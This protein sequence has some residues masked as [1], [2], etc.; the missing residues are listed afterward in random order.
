MD[1]TWYIP[2]RKPLSWLA[3]SRLSKR[4]L[5][6]DSAMAWMQL[7]SDVSPKTPLGGSAAS[8]MPSRAAALTPPD[9]HSSN[10]TRDWHDDDEGAE[11]TGSCAT[12]AT[13]R[14]GLLLLL[15]PPGSVSTL[16]LCASM[17]LRLS[18]SRTT[19][20]PSLHP[21][22]SAL[23]D[24]Q[25]ATTTGIDVPDSVT[26]D[27]AL[28]NTFSHVSERYRVKPPR[29]LTITSKSMVGHSAAACT[30][31]VRLCSTVKDDMET[32]VPRCER[33]ESHRTGVPYVGL[34]SLQV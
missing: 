12:H 18:R 16:R 4:L 31:V 30:A 28:V 17:V 23:P 15:L 6:V 1:T 33:G 29:V 8:I 32:G 13:R 21:M 19:T 22:P 11:A 27:A 7:P 3:A 25:N 26:S 20:C 10:R 14:M 5:R 24:A 9:F 34:E 2:N